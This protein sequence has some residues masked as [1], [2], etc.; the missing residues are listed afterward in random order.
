M[1]NNNSN[2]NSATSTYA[3]IEAI[4]ARWEL[5]IINGEL[6]IGRVEKRK[7]KLMQVNTVVDVIIDIDFPLHR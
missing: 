3:S 2:C 5:D 6:I 4:S 7:Y 1:D